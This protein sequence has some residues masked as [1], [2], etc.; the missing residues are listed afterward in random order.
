MRIFH[1]DKDKQ[2]YLRLLLDKGKTFGLQFLSYCLMPN[3]VHLIVVPE[4]TQGLAKGIGEAHRF[5][6]RMINFRENKRGNLFQGRF[7]SAPLDERYFM[8]AMRY[9]AR[10]PIQ[11]GMVKQAW[12][13]PWSSA[14]F[15]VGMRES[16]PIVE[17][18][19]PFGLNLE[20]MDLF[21]ED[22]VEA[23]ALQKNVLLGR[24][25]GDS[26]FRKKIKAFLSAQP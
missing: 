2:K 24:P 17:E 20:W 3:H 4:D 11:A 22:P 21:A 6:T 16:D 1:S 25:C 15:T 26:R 8:A 10:N 13:Y 5:Y 18:R 14:A 23:D 9:I 7:F 12:E 19:N